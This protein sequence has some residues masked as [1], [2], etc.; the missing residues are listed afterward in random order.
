MHRSRGVNDRKIK[1]K[2]MF[3]IDLLSAQS[4]HY[5]KFLASYFESKS[6]EVQE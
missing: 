3:A 6:R 1:V 5:M 4:C 2:V